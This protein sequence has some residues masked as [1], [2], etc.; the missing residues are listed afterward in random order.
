LRCCTP[1][2]KTCPEESAITGGSLFPFPGADSRLLFPGPLFFSRIYSP[3]QKGSSCA[4]KK[5]GAHPREGNFFLRLKEDG[6]EEVGNRH[7]VDTF[8]GLGRRYVYLSGLGPFRPWRRKLHRDLLRAG[9]L[10]ADV[11]VLLCAEVLSGVLLLSCM[12]SLL[13]AG[14]RNEEGQKEV[15]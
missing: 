5:P 9:S 2:W 3:G 15:R 6:Y 13:P 7:R 11:W 4:R 10:R 8:G 12:L 1:D 14:M